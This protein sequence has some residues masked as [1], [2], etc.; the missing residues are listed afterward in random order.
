MAKKKRRRSPGEGSVFEYKLKSG[1]ARWGIK[2]VTTCADG[3]RK[4]V[5]RRRDENGQPWTTETAARK[6]VRDALSKVDAGTW[7]DPSKQTLGEYLDTW[8]AGLRLGDSTV[9]SYKK[10]IRLHIK[11]YIGGVKLASLTSKKIDQVYRKLETGGRRDHKGELT[12]KPL[13]ARTVRYV[14]TILRAALQA[15]VDGE[16]AMLAKNPADKANPP[17]AKEAK[18]PEMHP[19]TNAQ[20]RTFLDWSRENSALHVAWFTL[21]Y[22][23]VRRGELLAL[24]WRD[25][26][27]DAGTISVRRSVGLSR[28]KGEKA[29]IKEGPTKTNQPRVIDIDP[30]TVALLRAHKRERGALALQLARNDALIFGDAEGEWRHPERFSRTFKDHLARCR[31]DLGKVE[32]V[33]APDEIRLHDLRHSHA[34]ILLRAGTNP[35]IVSERLGHASVTITMNVYAHCLPSMQREAVTRFASIMN[36]TG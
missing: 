24:R 34:T 36:A 2:F 26:D 35:K 30:E 29:Q 22:T 32:G 17:T 4:P 8:A 25:V 7:I 28:V 23:G 21:G 9:A 12:G 13:A 3:T 19:W 18:A 20:L 10:N 31:R 11:P 16:P 27:L 5:L 14:H 15:A 33:E 1:S 6:A